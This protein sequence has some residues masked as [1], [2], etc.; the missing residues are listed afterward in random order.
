MENDFSSAD[1]DDMIMEVEKNERSNAH[2]D[3]SSADEDEMVQEL[4]RVEKRKY[5]CDLCKSSYSRKTHLIRHMLAHKYHVQCSIC[6]RQFRRKDVLKRHMRNVHGLN[7]QTFPCNHCSN[8]YDT[9]D[10]LFTYVVHN[11]PLNQQ[12]QES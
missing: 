8:I 7:K 3:F 6:K 1:E 9:Y 4:E 5:F 11:H 10:E 2:T 12:P